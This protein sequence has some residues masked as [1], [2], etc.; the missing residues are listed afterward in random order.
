[1]PLICD[2]LPYDKL[3]KLNSRALRLPETHPLRK[4]CADGDVRVFVENNVLVIHSAGGFYFEHMTVADVESELARH[5]RTPRT[6]HCT[7]FEV[8]RDDPSVV[9]KLLDRFQEQHGV[10]MRNMID[11]CVINYQ[12]KILMLC[13]L[14][15]CIL[16]HMLAPTGGMMKTAYSGPVDKLSMVP[17]LAKLGVLSHDFSEDGRIQSMLVTEY[18]T[19]HYNAV[20]RLHWDIVRE[21]IARPYSGIT[22]GPVAVWDA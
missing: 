21:V 4:E 2:A 16:R 13:K 11:W 17:T 6:Y 3:S 19:E 9:E 22:L 18:K 15:P 20:K 5:I 8:D 12:G 10:K 14:P 1:M 7:A